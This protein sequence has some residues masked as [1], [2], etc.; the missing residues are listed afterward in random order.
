[1][2]DI[3][4]YIQTALKNG[5]KNRVNAYRN[6]KSKILL[7]QTA[8]NAKGYDDATELSIIGKYVKELNEDSKAYFAANRNDLAVEYVEEADILS[9]FL[10]NEPTEDEIK[11]AI[12]EFISLNNGPISDTKTLAKSQMGSCIKYVKNQYPTADGKKVSEVVKSFIV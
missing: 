3:D 12:A 4:K 2:I 5:E 6:L 9:E 8:K 11:I 1:M 10:P 7:A